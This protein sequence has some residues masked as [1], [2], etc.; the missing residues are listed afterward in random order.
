MNLIKSTYKIRCEM[1]ACKNFAGYTI[2]MDRVGIKSRIHVCESC[3]RQLYSLIGGE[4]V[5][6]SCETVKKGALSAAKSI[7]SV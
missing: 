5:P 2:K 3:L 7:K 1:G 6:Q 4:M